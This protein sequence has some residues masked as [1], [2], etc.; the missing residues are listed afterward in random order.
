MLVREQARVMCRCVVFVNVCVPTL[1]MPASAVSRVS[2]SVHPTPLFLPQLWCFGWP[3]VPE[4][5]TK[6]LGKGC[7]ALSAG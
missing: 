3:A 4:L 1:P 6:Q 2:H 5:A 7:H